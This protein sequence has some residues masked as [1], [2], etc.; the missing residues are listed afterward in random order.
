M[1]RSKF[2]VLLF[3]IAFAGVDVLGQSAPAPVK[4][5]DTVSYGFVIDNSGSYRTLLERVINLV[6]EVARSNRENDE[7]FLV[8]FVDNPKTVIR[9][10]FTSNKNDLIDAANNMYIEGG[11]TSLLD[12]L[13]LSIDYFSANAKEEPD[14]ARAILFVTDGDDRSSVAKVETV[15]AAAKAAKIRIVIVGMTDDKLGT[16]ILDRLAKETGGRTFYP[17]TAKETGTIAADV[18]AAIRGN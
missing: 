9:Q 12:A 1:R 2:I 8:T 5:F 15:I 6:E 17:K 7:A 3:S 11:Q 10:E 14:R 16:K 18:V 4:T 13:R